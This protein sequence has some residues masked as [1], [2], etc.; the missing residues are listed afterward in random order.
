MKE[1]NLQAC[2]RDQTCLTLMDTRLE[3]MMKT[4]GILVLSH[5]E[6]RKSRTKDS[7]HNIELRYIKLHI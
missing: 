7:E 1:S 3:R 4:P 2:P 6:R 5:V